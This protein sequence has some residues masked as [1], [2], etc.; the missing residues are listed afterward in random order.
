MFGRSRFALTGYYFQGLRASDMQSTIPLCAAAAGLYVSFRPPRSRADASA[1]T[2]TAS[3]LPA[4]SGPN[5]QR[6]TS[7]L[8]WRAPFVF[9]GG[10]LWTL[11]AHARGDL[12]H[13][14]NNDPGRF[15]RRTGQEPICRRAAFPMLALDWRWPFVTDSRSGKSSYVLEPV[16]QLIAQ[17]Y[18]GN[19]V[20]LPIE[21]ADAFEFDDNNLFS[22]NQLPGYDLVESGPRANVGFI[23]DALFKGGEIQ[24]LVGQTYRLKPDPI[25]ANFAGE[26]GTA[27]D[28]IGRVSLKFP[29][30]DFTDRLDL[31]RGNG[32]LRRHEIYVTGTYGR[33][34]VQVAYVQLPAAGA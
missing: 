6:F 18:G 9:G 23:A 14:D 11:I 13:I 20:G 15:S 30:L 22:V 33:S 25:F 19:P 24:G 16:A 27:S 5:S 17:P 12:Y 21:D 1:S 32:T 2:S 4:S 3:R 7:E 26:N 34:S 31:D 8:D 29:H 28:V 10:Q